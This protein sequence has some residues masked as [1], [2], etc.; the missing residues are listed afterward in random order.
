MESGHTTACGK[1]IGK[2]VEEEGSK[3]MEGVSQ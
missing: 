1:K 2:E 3:D